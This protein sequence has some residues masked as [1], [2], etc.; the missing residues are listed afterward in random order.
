MFP[1]LSR[2]HHDQNLCFVVNQG[3]PIK[4]KLTVGQDADVTSAFGMF[5]DLAEGALFLGEMLT[6][7]TRC[8]RWS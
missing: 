2:R 4:L 5:A 1:P 3:R 8:A 7:P 6:P